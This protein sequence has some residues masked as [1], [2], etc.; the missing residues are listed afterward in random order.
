M[1]GSSAWQPARRRPFRVSKPFETARSTQGYRM[2]GYGQGIMQS[3]CR[4]HPHQMS[5]RSSLDTK[6]TCNTT[7]ARQYLA[8]RSDGGPAGVRTL[9]LGIKSPLLYQ[10]SYRSVYVRNTLG[11]VQ[12]LEPWTYGTT[13]RRSSQLG[14]THRVPAPSALDYYCRS[15][16]RMQVLFST[17]LADSPHSYS[18]YHFCR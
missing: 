14:Y 8:F 9:D 12:G 10:L 11:W 6:S 5:A 7:K 17:F 2:P 16:I 13:T 4:R 15:P 1:D 3:R 18:G